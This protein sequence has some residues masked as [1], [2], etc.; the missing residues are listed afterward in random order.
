MKMFS[1]TYQNVNL[2]GKIA[3]AQVFLLISVEDTTIVLL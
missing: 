2:F 3:V 1:F